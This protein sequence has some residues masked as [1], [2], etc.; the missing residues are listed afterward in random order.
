MLGGGLRLAELLAQVP[1]DGVEPV[2]AGQA[3]VQ[4]LELREA[5]VQAIVVFW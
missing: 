2:I 4:R 3:G 5:G 1:A